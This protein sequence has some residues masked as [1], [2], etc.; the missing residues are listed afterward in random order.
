MLP[1]FRDRI[2]AKLTDEYLPKSTLPDSEGEWALIDSIRFPMD[3]EDLV[4]EEQ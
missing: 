4:L 1:Y 2:P 3:P